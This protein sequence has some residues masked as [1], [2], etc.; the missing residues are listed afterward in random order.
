MA[1]DLLGWLGFAVLCFYA[2][3]WTWGIRVKLDAGI[4][5]VSATTFFVIS[6]LLVGFGYIGRIH[7]WWLVPAGFIWNFLALYAVLTRIPLLFE[8]VVLPAALYSRLV[9]I[10]IPPQEIRA[11]QKAAIERAID[12]VM[13]REEREKTVTGPKAFTV[14]AR[15]A[16]DSQ[17]GAL[18]DAIV[19]AYIYANTQDRTVQDEEN[20]E[21]ETTDPYDHI[22]G[23]LKTLANPTCFLFVQTLYNASFPTHVSVNGQRIRILE[24]DELVKDRAS[25]IGSFNLVFGG[26][27]GWNEIAAKYEKMGYDRKRLETLCVR[28][29]E[30]DSHNAEFFNECLRVDGFDRQLKAA[31]IS[32]DG[33]W[34]SDEDM[35]HLAGYKQFK[36]QYAS[37]GG[38]PDDLDELMRAMMDVDQTR[39]QELRK[40]MG[41]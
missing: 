14:E 28:W 33:H 36:A 32:K 29:L 22:P 21:N 3:T 41:A 5:F 8:I 20:G 39:Y 25:I 24:P 40:R 19:N 2:I 17:Q 6:A 1:Y 38:N 15:A 4:P 18:F 12:H 34:G 37:D 16:I 7:S 35:L 27:R 31:T 26:R 10:G 13:Q 9:R 11:S 30:G 23:F